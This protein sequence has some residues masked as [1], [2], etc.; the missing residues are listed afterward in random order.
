MKRALSLCAVGLAG[1]AVAGLG[2]AALGGPEATKVSPSFTLK[3]SAPETEKCEGVDG[4]YTTDRLSATGR[5]GAGP[6]AGDVTLDL[7]WVKNAKENIGWAEG[8][9]VVATDDEE[10]SVR[11][12]VVGALTGSTLR[13]TIVGEVVDGGRLLGTISIVRTG[14]SYAVKI[15]SGTTAGIAVIAAGDA[16]V[17]PETVTGE[18]VD[19]DLESG[20][21]SVESADDYV[22]V[23]FTEAQAA[24]IERA[25]IDLGSRVKLTYAEDDEGNVELIEIA[26][27]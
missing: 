5:I 20:Y 23:T 3:A 19:I 4:E 22:T 10:E 6:L 26:L 11:A 16:C 25:G 21:L 27:Q 13:G 17:T 1:L 14:N 15:G 7:T 8:T 12:D 18:V 9:F 24:A 2:I